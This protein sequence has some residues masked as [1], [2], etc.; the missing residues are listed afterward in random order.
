MAK[1][2]KDQRKKRQAKAKAVPQ[3]TTMYDVIFSG[4]MLIG[5]GLIYAI[6]YA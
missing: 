1:P 5:M 6:F 3:D 2:Q 4:A